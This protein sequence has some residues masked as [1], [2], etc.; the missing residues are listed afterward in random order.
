VERK[1]DED[2]GVKVLEVQECR[3]RGRPKRT[4]EQSVKYDVRK[5]GMQRVEPFDKD[6]WRSYCGS[7][8]PT[9]ASMEK[10]R[11]KLFD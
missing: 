8:R 2:S 10:K 3:G 6:K 11:Y 1:D 7:H 5:Y 9:R 4:W